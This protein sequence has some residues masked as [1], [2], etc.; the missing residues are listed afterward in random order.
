ML[1]LQGTTILGTGIAIVRREFHL[2]PCPDCRS[3]RWRS[4]RA[5]LSPEL[6]VTE[7]G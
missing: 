6:L 1:A 7:N 5:D 3:L 2:G 4:E